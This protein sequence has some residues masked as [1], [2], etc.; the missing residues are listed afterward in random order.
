MGQFQQATFCY[1]NSLPIMKKFG[2]VLGCAE[3]QYH[4]GQVYMKL[5]NWDMAIVELNEAKQIYDELG[6]DDSLNEVLGLLYT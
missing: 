3:S 1:T 2:E 6:E 5:N 4:L